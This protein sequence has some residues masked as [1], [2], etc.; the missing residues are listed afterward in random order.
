MMKIFFIG[1][2]IKAK[3]EMLLK[4]LSFHL[5][6]KFFAIALASFIINLARFWVDLKK[7]PAKVS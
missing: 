7:A 2:L 5:Q 4:I 6:L 1:A 3:I